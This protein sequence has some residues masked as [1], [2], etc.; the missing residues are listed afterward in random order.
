MHKP[1]VAIIG[2][3]PAGL[4]A[5]LASARAGARVEIF[6]QMPSPAR[7]FLMAGR[8][9]L[10]LTH[11][12]PLDQF[13]TRYGAARDWLRTILAR[14]TPQQMR[15]FAAAYGEETFVGSSGRV[16]PKSFKA[17]PLLRAWLRDLQQLGVVLHLRH[18]FT[19]FDDTGALRF[20]T[21][22]GEREVVADACVMALGGASWSRLGSDGRWL[23]V[24]QE[25]GL[26]VAP[27]QPANCGFDIA[28]S[29]FMEAHAGEPLKSIELQACGHVLRG[30]CVVTQYGLEGGAIYAL[31]S[32][33]REEIARAGFATLQIDLRPDVSVEILAQKL[34]RPRGKQSLS[35]HLRKSAGLTSA[36]A[37][38]LR[39]S[40]PLPSDAQELA[41]RI[42]SVCLRLV[43]AHGLERAIS[44]AGG[45]QLSQLDEGLMVKS[46]PGL[47]LAGEML[48]WEAPTG[49]YLLQA[50]FASGLVAGEAAAAFAARQSPP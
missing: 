44:T 14:F 46:R 48:D 37:A 50:C 49:G 4:M 5:A 39:E 32:V 41:Q 11:S 29:P 3:G 12:E 17:S 2:A 1:H 7:K 35:S 40:G 24:L 15:D 45:V 33:L 22:Q 43:R 16:F 27:L 25:A 10:N 23:P 31:S 26:A 8:G 6:E 38:V 18:S 9:G 28:W 36:G 47:F 19:G 13:V 30:E 42:K 34:A 21:P 20:A